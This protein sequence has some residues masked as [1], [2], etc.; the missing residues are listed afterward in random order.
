[1][2]QHN[3][4]LGRLILNSFYFLILKFMIFLVRITYKL[5]AMCQENLPVNLRQYPNDD[6]LNIS[7]RVQNNMSDI[8]SCYLG[9][10]GR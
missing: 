4:A 2:L 6:F 7:L 10:R 3:V 9:F 8:S 1:M 5:Y